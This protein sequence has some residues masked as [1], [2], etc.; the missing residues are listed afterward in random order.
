MDTFSLFDINRLTRSRPVGFQK[1]TPQML[2]K[3][4]KRKEWN[5]TPPENL[6]YTALDTTAYD[7]GTVSTWKTPSGGT[8]AMTVDSLASGSIRQGIK[9]STL[10]QTPPNGGTNAVI[11]DF[12]LFYMTVTMASAPT[13]G[14]EF[15][16]YLGFSDSSAAGTD[17]P[18]G[19][20]GTD[21]AGP[22]V[23]TLPQLVFA[24]SVIASANISG[25][26]QFSYLS[27]VPPLNAYVSPVVYNNMSVA[28]SSSASFTLS[29][30]PYYRQRAT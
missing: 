9:S 3:L 30:A 2:R 23:D 12:L 16:L 18:A 11:P 14:G 21:A 17:N 20:S 28:A 13:A 15:G 25:N 7:V 5:Y 4:A 6:Y 8:Y 1:L 29:M 19:L 24:G 27:P 22:N 26:V 10:I